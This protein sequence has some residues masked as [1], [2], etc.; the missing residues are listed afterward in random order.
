MLGTAAVA[1]CARCPA[2]S[3]RAEEQRLHRKGLLS[4]CYYG[5]TTVPVLQ[6]VHSLMRVLEGFTALVRGL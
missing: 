2:L 1:Y 6:Y 4:Y 5:T 3:A